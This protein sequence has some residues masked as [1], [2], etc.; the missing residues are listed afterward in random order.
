[1]DLSKEY[2]Y[3]D[4]L[5]WQFSERVELIKGKIFKMS[6]APLRSH[7][8]ISFALALQI[9]NYLMGKSFDAYTAPFDVRLVNKRKS[10][11]DGQITSVVQPDICVICDKGKLDE[12]GCV[13]AP[14]WII[15][16]LSP[17]NNRKEMKDKYRLYEENGVKEY[18]VVYPEYVQ[19]EVFDLINDRFVLRSHYINEDV[20]V[21][22][23]DDFS[24]D[25]T[26]V[27]K[28]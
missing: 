17:G 22:I 18:W 13:G 24:I 28:I 3:A 12:R 1:L 21:K 6:P 11:P 20:P 14:D 27:F 16:I 7:Q 23:F 26:G 10:T 9:G 8:Q 5:T 25:A 19:V 4:Y 2:T 15:E